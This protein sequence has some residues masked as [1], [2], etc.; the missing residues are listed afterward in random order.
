MTMWEEYHHQNMA[1]T[2]LKLA[3]LNTAI[4]RNQVF[5]V[6]KFLGQTSSKVLIAMGFLLKILVGRRLRSLS[7]ILGPAYVLAF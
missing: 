1:P 7:F 2:T 3:K 6:T 4:H 5:S